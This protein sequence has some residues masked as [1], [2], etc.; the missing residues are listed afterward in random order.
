MDK[1]KLKSLMALHGH[2]N[3]DIAELLDITEQS[4]SKKINENGSEFKQGEMAK[5]RNRYNLSPAEFD[6]IFFAN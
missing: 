6:A 5:I 4:V 3:R 1:A 2:T